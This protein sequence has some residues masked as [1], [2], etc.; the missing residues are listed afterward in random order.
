MSRARPTNGVKS[1]AAQ[2]AQMKPKA[3]RSTMKY[4]PILV[5]EKT[6]AKMLD[7]TLDEFRELVAKG[8][9]PAPVDL[10][11]IDRWRVEELHLIVTA[12]AFEND[13]EDFVA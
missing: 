12:A 6:A 2:A 5:R 7:L 1:P 13:E 11:G 10:D 8:I 4:Q 9:L 3:D